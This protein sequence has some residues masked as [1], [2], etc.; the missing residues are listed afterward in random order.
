MKIE[1]LL[2][3]EYDEQSE[4][5]NEQISLC[6]WPSGHAEGKRPLLHWILFAVFSNPQGYLSCFH[7]LGC[8]PGAHYPAGTREPCAAQGAHYPAGTRGNIQAAC[9]RRSPLSGASGGP[10][11]CCP[12]STCIWFASPKVFTIS[13]GL[14]LRLI[15]H[16]QEVLMRSARRFRV[17][18]NKD[19]VLTRRGE[20]DLV[21]I[22]QLLYQ[23]VDISS[24]YASP[25]LFQNF[26][27]LECR[28]Q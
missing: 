3:P 19:A 24:Y 8:C 6:C 23:C 27:E 25:F 21:H 18:S 15:A 11:C 26:K 17:I 9:G 1:F 28:C 16:T 12:R 7:A 20:T 2:L 10:Q 14:T 4:R 13:R 22:R 5:K